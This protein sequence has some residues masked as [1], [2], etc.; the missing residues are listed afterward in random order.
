MCIFKCCACS[1]VC[2]VCLA[3]SRSGVRFLLPTPPLKH[4]STHLL[5]IISS[6]FSSWMG[7]CCELCAVRAG[8]GF[9]VEYSWPRM[10]V[11]QSMSMITAHSRYFLMVVSDI[12]NPYTVQNIHL[13]HLLLDSILHSFRFIPHRSRPQHLEICKGH[14][15]S[16]VWLSLP[17]YL[18]AVRNSFTDMLEL[19]QVLF[20]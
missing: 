6:Y 2:S 7:W 8:Q 16:N 11:P 5:W 12:Q 1:S 20:L 19:W 4:P 18:L 14:R 15:V 3:C 9:D 13:T 10:S 17:V